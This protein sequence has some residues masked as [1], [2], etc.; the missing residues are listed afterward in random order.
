MATSMKLLI[1]TQNQTKVDRIKGILNYLDYPIELLSLNGFNIPEPDEPYHTFA[2]NALHKANYYSKITGL[3]TLSEDSGLCINA[4]NG[5]PGVRTKEFKE[6][7]GGID[8]ACTDLQNRLKN[9]PDHSAYLICAACIVLPETN[10]ILTAE[11]RLN[12]TISNTPF[13]DHGFDFERI[14]IANG[15]DKTLADMDVRDKNQISHRYKAIKSV[16]EQLIKEPIF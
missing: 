5:F 12:G 16:Y 13:K 7:S 14:F 4:L 2:E 1:A 10:K 15:H 9:L 6:A 3:Q 11:G 8:A